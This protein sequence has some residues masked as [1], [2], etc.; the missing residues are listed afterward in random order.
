LDGSSPTKAGPKQQLMTRRQYA[1]PLG[2]DE[3]DDGGVNTPENP[4]K[5]STPPTPIHGV[6]NNI[7]IHLLVFLQ[8]S[9][10]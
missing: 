7:S 10:C 3:E 6:N 2:S 5:S 8:N 9:G 4:S 1:D